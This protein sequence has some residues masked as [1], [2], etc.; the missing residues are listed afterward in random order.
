MAKNLLGK[1]RKTDNPYMTYIGHGFEYRVLKTYQSKEAESKNA[2]A[3]WFLATMS[4]HTF[5]QWELG[6][7][8][9]KDIRGLECTFKSPEAIEAGY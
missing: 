9:A 4:P 6:D 8:Y 5:G 7:G 3:R 1:T 2:F